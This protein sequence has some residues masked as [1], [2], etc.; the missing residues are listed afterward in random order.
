M[1]HA[2]GGEFLLA[3]GD[4]IFFSGEPRPPPGWVPPAYKWCCG[5]PAACA[6]GGTSWLVREGT[7]ITAG[8]AVTLSGTYRC[9]T[10]LAS[11]S[12]LL[13]QPFVAGLL[14]RVTEV[15]L[16]H[17]LTPFD[18]SLEQLHDPAINAAFNTKGGQHT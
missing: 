15:A 1:H 12:T 3:E 4:I 5:V 17:G 14:D 10:P 7:H 18:S 13:H 16:S 8:Q 11:F 2:V 6:S 9:S